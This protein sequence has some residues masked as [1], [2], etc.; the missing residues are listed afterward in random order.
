MKPSLVRSIRYGSRSRSMEWF[1]REGWNPVEDLRG[2]EKENFDNKITTNPQKL[3]EKD[4]NFVK[5]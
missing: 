5:Q 1:V 3:M 4:T 2:P